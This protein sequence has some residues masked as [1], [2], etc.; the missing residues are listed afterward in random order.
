VSSVSDD[1]VIVLLRR[2]LDAEAGS[3]AG[4]ARRHGLAPQFV[5][6][7]YHRRKPPSEAIG[8]ALGLRRV[9]DWQPIEE[10]RSP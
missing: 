4:W 3:R 8:R 1:D 9:T 2:I 10:G 6:A 7:V 5:H